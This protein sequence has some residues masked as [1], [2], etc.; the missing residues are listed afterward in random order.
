MGALHAGHVALLARAREENTSVVASIF[1][2]P[3]QFG[4]GEDFERYPRVFARDME[5]L[6]ACG[7]SIAY[8]PSLEQMYPA[9]F[10]TAVDAGS[11]SEV[12]EGARR[13]GH[14]RG[15]ATVV[16]KLLHAIEPTSLYLGQKDVQQAAVVRAMVRDLDMPTNVVVVPTVREADGL[17]LSSR[18]VYLSPAERSA[19]PSLH[20]A[21]TAAAAALAA[22]A[23]D[24]AQVV[25]AARGEL[26][27]PLAWDYFAVVDPQTFAPL[28]RAERPALV[29]GV[30][31]AGKTRLI[32]NVTVPTAAGVDP[33]VTPPRPPSA[34]ALP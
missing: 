19:A 13:P 15:V 27:E 26:A 14:F 23:T 24:V 16:M 20:R 7:V 9:G 21:L 12:F 2:N 31:R 6:E 3:L 1:V 11:L 30:A 34:R 28:E 4:P 5:I 8:A 10:A 18:N 22:G 29:I 17:A 33:I 32:D 25:A